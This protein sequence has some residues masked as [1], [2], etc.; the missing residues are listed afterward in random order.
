MNPA[1]DH[2]IQLEGV[3]KS[4]GAQH[5]LRG[6]DLGIP[7]GRITVIIGRS[8]GGKSVILKHMIGLIKPD[9]GRVLLDGENITV[10]D[11]RQLNDIRRRFGMLFQD[12]ALF[13][14]MNVLENVAFPLRE[15]TELD[16]KIVDIAVRMK[17]GLVGLSGF[18]NRLPR[19][20]SGGQ[21]K[22]VAFARAIALDPEVL[23]CD[24]PSAGLD[25][26]IGRG[27]DDLILNLNKAFNMAVVVVTH[28]MESVKVIADR[29]V[30]LVAR[31]GG[32]KVAFSGSYEEMKRCEDPEVA[33]F[34]A[35]EPLKEPRAEALEILKQLTGEK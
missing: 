19:E 9:Q 7:R 11:D 2:I 18:E 33:A 17:L 14:S 34:V 6:I 10:M 23:F 12:A 31:A 16:D 28:E 25:P 29:I 3:H 22:R 5:V 30:M 1:A 20:L 32:A 35:R 24:E 8:G 27:I 21:A 13:D 15:H 4:F 26:R